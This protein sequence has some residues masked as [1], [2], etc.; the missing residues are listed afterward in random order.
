[1]PVCAALAVPYLPAGPPAAVEGG[2]CSFRGIEPINLPFLEK[3]LASS[4]QVW[5]TISEFRTVCR[6]PVCVR[7]PDWQGG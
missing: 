3:I 7:G 6:L 2:G 5:Y 1:M 4:W